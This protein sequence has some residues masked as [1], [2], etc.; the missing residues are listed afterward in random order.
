MPFKQLLMN[1]SE[2][3]EVGGGTVDKKDWEDREI[4]EKMMI[5]NRRSDGVKKS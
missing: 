2:S 4:E 3:K 1:R 5:K